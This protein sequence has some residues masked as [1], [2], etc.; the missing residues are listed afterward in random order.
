M[1]SGG[2]DTYQ[3]T[4]LIFFLTTVYDAQM[5]LFQGVGYI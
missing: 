3:I 1:E 4:I 2:I 5:F